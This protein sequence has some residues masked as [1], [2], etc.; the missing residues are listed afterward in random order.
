MM[1]LKCCTQY[2]SK[3]GKVSSG[4]RTGKTLIFIPFES[5]RREMPENV[6]TTMQLCSFHTLAR[7]CSKSFKQVSAVCEPRTSRCANWVWKRQRNQRS[8]C[9]HS[10]DHRKSKGI[11]EKTT[12]SAL[13]IMLKPLTMWIT[14]N[15]GKF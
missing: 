4:H 3:F 10:L 13:L 6:P 8:N 7:L 11:P 15:C 1:L 9:Q 12:I 2:V 14:I 5:Q